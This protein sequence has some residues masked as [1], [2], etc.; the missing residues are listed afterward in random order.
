[1]VLWFQTTLPASQLLQTCR[2]FRS[3]TGARGLARGLALEFTTEIAWKLDGSFCWFMD[4]Y[5]PALVTWRLFQLVA[6]FS[7]EESYWMAGWW[8]GTF[9][10]FP[11]IGNNHPNRLSYF[12]EGFKPPTRWGLSQSMNGESLS[13]HQY[14]PVVPHLR[15]WRKFQN[16]KPIGEVGGC[17]SRMTEQIHWWTERWLELCFFFLSAG[18]GCSGHLTQNCW[19]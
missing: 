7:V 8:F 14:I 16:R 10:I 2:F 9:F 5:Q 3:E 17:D 19:M 1:M 11:Y 18:N 15:Q 12:S 6:S 13:T 4:A